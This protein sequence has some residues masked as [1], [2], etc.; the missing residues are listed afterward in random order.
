MDGSEKHIGLMNDILSE[1]SSADRIT[2]ATARHME[3]IPDEAEHL[4]SEVTEIVGDSPAMDAQ[5]CA[6]VI[7][8]AERILQDLP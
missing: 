1:K 5:D 8:V 2:T 3:D 6:C 7:S 4:C